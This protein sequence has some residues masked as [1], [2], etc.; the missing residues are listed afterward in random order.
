MKR[1]PGGWA[2][3]GCG[4]CNEDGGRASGAVARSRGAPG[5]AEVG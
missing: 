5:V 4:H 3:R 2:F 1:R